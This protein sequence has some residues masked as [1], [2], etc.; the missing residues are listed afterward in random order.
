MIKRLLEAE[1]RITRAA[2]NL[3]A[4]PISCSRQDRAVL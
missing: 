2:S 4:Q 3:T 1:D